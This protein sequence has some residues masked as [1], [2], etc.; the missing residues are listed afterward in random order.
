LVA[1]KYLRYKEETPVSMFLSL[2]R[3]R[4]TNTKVYLTQL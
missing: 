4:K 1:Q 3:K 2:F